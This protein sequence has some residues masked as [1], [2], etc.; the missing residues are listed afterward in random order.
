MRT[1][2][3]ICLLDGRLLPTQRQQRPRRGVCTVLSRRYSLLST[4][5]HHRLGYVLLRLRLDLVIRILPLTPHLLSLLLVLVSNTLI[6]RRM[7]VIVGWIM[8]NIVRGR[9]RGII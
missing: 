7:Y 6:I 4:K 2:I 9:I 5:L 1:W 8:E 3:I